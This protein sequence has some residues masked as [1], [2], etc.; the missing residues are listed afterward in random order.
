[1]PD[2]KVTT[3]VIIG[4]TATGK[5]DLAVFLAKKFNGEVISADSRQV[6]KGMDLGT[7]KITKKEMKN[8]P[9]YL[10]DEVSPKGSFDVTR[11]KQKAEKAI[12][13]INAKG[14]I[15]I[16][17]GGTGFWIDAL[18]FN[19]SFPDVPPNPTL[20][21]KLEF[22]PAPSLF[23]RLQKLDP[24]RAKT[25]DSHNPHRL[26]R[27]IE[28]AEHNKKHKKETKESK[29]SFT[30]SPIFIGLDIPNDTLY[31]KIEKRLK[32]RFKKGMIAEVARL[33]KNG[34]SWKKLESFGLEYR[35]IAQYLQGKVSEDKMIEDLNI[36]VRQ[37]A[38]RQRTWFKRNKEI[39]WFDPTKKSS[40]NK[41]LKLIKV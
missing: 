39:H 14:K 12:Q 13:K 36:A 5:S 11:F 18:V 40:L 3:I 17:A 33:H 23:K 24:Q 4:P 26:I 25:I 34:V 10:L 21:K 22:E 28:I 15:P 41:I 16:I 19:Q 30:L 20:R 32:Q 1:M 6:Y 9:H 38:K 29:R 31:E 37:Y 2:Q 35:H 7:G 8:I 27:A